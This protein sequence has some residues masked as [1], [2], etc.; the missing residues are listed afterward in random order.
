VLPTHDVSSHT[1]P[2]GNHRKTRSI[3]LVAV[4]WGNVWFKGLGE[5]KRKLSGWGVYI[6]RTGKPRETYRFCSKLFK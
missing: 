3:L 1:I 2:S 5:G 6:M 4:V